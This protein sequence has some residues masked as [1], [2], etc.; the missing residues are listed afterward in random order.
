[1]SL[2]LLALTGEEERR[3]CK[4]K[5]ERRNRRKEIKNKEEKNLRKWLGERFME[6]ML[7]TIEEKRK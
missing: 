3:E 1:M 5:W 7:K 6:R 2:K 4:R